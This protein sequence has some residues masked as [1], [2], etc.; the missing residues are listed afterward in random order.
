MFVST[1]FLLV[2]VVALFFGDTVASEASWSGLRYLLA[3][4]IPRTRLLRRAY[5][6]DTPA[7]RP[8]GLGV[9]TSDEIA[10]LP[11]SSMTRKIVAGLG[12]AQRPLDFS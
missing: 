6:P 2:V 8:F 12:T 7:S 9:T 5:S 3:A 10:G 1:G 11:V 4:P